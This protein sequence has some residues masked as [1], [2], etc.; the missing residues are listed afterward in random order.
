V[1]HGFCD[2]TVKNTA[3]CDAAIRFATAVVWTGRLSERRANG[4]TR[5]EYP[6]RHL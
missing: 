4:T 3:R 6:T 5:Q 1:E 2:S